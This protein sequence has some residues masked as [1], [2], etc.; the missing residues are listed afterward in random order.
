M[1]P[2]VPELPPEIPRG[3]SALTAWLG[4]RVLAVLRWR[5]VG[6]L[7]DLS[8]LVIIVGPHTSAWDLIVGLAAKLALHIEATFLAKH[9]LFFWPLGSLLRSLGGIPV[10]RSGSHDVVDQMAQH[11]DES[12]ELVL[13]LAP[14]G[15][16]RHVEHWKSGFYYIAQRARVPIVPAALDFENRR[17]R[18]GPPLEP[19]GDPQAEVA[20]LRRFIDQA[21]ARNPEKA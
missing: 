12:E 21:G 11:F 16:R 17:I 8:K 1:P 3:G 6:Q 2:I 7:P 14:E 15:T 19:A 18:F 13:V 5:V 4:R 20:V 9:T 10:D